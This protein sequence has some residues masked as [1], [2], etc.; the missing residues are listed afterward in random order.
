ME[1][2]FVNYTILVFMFLAIILAILSG[3][4][5][6]YKEGTCSNDGYYILSDGSKLKSEGEANTLNWE[7]ARKDTS[8]YGN[9]VN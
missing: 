6:Q 3:K 9:I 7:K 8:V 1:D 2:K 4:P 5:Y